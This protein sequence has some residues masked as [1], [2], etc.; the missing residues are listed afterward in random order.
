MLSSTDSPTSAASRSIVA[1]N[2]DQWMAL[3][4]SLPQ[5]HAHVVRAAQLQDN[6]LRQILKSVNRLGRNTRRLNRA[7][8]KLN[9]S[10]LVLIVFTALLAV[11]TITLVVAS[12]KS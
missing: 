7:V 10:T 11:L 2:T 6:T 4:S 5:E 3:T 12:V 8:E 9:R 1:D